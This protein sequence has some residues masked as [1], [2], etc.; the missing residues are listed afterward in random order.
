MNGA[1]YSLGRFFKGAV[2]VDWEGKTL[3]Y[4]FNTDIY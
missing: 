2:T 3:Q 1:H 4:K